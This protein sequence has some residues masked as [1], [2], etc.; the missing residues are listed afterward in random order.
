[1]EEGLDGGRPLPGDGGVVVEVEKDICGAGGLAVSSR[2][3][4][5]DRRRTGRS[6]PVNFDLQRRNESSNPPRPALSPHDLTLRI[7]V[8]RYLHS[9]LAAFLPDA[10]E[11]AADL[12][13]WGRKL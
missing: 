7:E 6:I 1:M 8:V 5:M 3:A 12:K 11:E 2:W 4:E 13:R 9:D 10:E